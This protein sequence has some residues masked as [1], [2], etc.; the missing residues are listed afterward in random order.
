[1]GDASYD[2]GQGMPGLL[3]SSDS[4]EEHEIVRPDAPEKPITDF[5]NQ[6]F[7]KEPESPPQRRVLDPVDS[8]NKITITDSDLSSIK[9]KKKNEGKIAMLE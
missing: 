1:M 9:I 3:N 7:D 6:V 4:M 8:P 5:Y 2:I